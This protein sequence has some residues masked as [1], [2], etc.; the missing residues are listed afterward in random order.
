VIFGVFRRTAFRGLDGLA[1]GDIRAF[2]ISLGFLRRLSER[3]VVGLAGE[4]GR[5]ILPRKYFWLIVVRL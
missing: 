1:E 2:V 3:L 4:F 5:L